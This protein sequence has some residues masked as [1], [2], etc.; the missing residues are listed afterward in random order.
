MS[1]LDQITYQSNAQN[2][3]ADIHPSFSA[4]TFEVVFNA[5]NCRLEIAEN[6][7]FRAL[8]LYFLSD[9]THVRIGAGT[10]CN[11]SFWANL[12]G[13]GRSISIGE[14]CLLASVKARTSDAHHI[15][16]DATGKMINPAG[17][18]V[19]SDRVWIAE[20]VLLLKGTVIGEESV[21]GAKSMVNSEIPPH[22][23]AA[24][25]PAKVLRSDI[26]WRYSG[27]HLNP[28]T[29]PTPT[30]KPAK[31][32][33]AVPA[34]AKPAKPAPPAAV[35]LPTAV[36][37]FWRQLR[38]HVAPGILRAGDALAEKLWTYPPE[39]GAKQKT[40]FL[41][42]LLNDKTVLL[43]KGGPFRFRNFYDMAV[44][45]DEILCTVQYNFEPAAEARCIIDAG[46]CYGLA[47]YL[48]HRRHP[49]ADILAF[50]PNPENAA[51]FRENIERIGMTNVTLE[52]AAV[53]TSNGTV[54]F[55][56]APGMP[57]GS[58]TSSHLAVKGFETTLL[59]VRQIDLPALIETRPVDLLKL[60]VE[61]SEYDI[62]NALDGRMRN[63]R[64]LF[65]ELHFGTD[66]PKSKIAPLLSVLDRNGFD[67]MIVR[68]SAN[69]AAPPHPL[70]S[71]QEGVWDSSLNLWA[72]PLPALEDAHDTRERLA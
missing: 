32:Q 58:S 47:S 61:G 3:S 42:M 7:K 52:E 4:S 43:L 1:F 35:P 36:A 39:S 26:S 51:V 10:L 37:D 60:D 53:G 19:V 65:I 21:I 16:D 59:Q 56:A 24:G 68:A 25:I 18:I 20:D 63:I 23:L 46:G 9:N 27:A 13:A 67:H 6:C 55:Y 71:L 72:R 22:S 29:V 33:P 31:P 64:N 66:M 17:N 5:K 70:A 8:K 38:R 14:H 50:E 48:F 41:Q 34:I 40:R 44:Q 11:S 54:E 12:S 15:I 2:C 62:L 28:P 45:L 57:M 49:R 30:A 69:N